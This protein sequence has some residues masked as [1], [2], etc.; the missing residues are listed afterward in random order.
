VPSTST[1]GASLRRRAGPSLAFK[2]RNPRSG[3]SFRTSDI[4]LL[5]HSGGLLPGLPELLPLEKD[6]TASATAAKAL[7]VLKRE[8]VVARVVLAWCAQ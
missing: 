2:E 4:E 3:S 1:P 7:D 8:G 5:V 6:A